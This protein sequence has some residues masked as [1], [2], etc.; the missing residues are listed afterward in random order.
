MAQSY[1]VAVHCFRLTRNDALRLC[2]V[3]YD[4]HNLRALFSCSCRL[5]LSISMTDSDP[6]PGAKRVVK[7]IECWRSVGV[8]F[9]IQRCR[10]NLLP[11]ASGL[12][13]MHT[14]SCAPMSIAKN[15][16]ATA[17]SRTTIF[18][19]PRAMFLSI[20]PILLALWRLF[21]SF[22]IVRLRVAVLYGSSCRSV[23]HLDRL[24]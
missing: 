14:I 13:P 15:R 8:R 20:A 16:F 23:G 7:R 22:E 11:V 18:Q 17:R 5:R 3:C 2:H 6:S 1:K 10:R 21:F 12:S 24:G 9:E 4:F 19:E